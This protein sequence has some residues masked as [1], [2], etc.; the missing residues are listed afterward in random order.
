MFKGILLSVAASSLLIL[1]GCCGKKCCSKTCTT[2]ECAVE[3]VVPTTE[4]PIEVEATPV[5]ETE[6]ELK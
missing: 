3:T 4:A 2:A 5:V 1:A 6:K